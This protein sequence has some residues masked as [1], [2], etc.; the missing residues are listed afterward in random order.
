MRGAA[1]AGSNMENFELAT[2]AVHVDEG[3]LSGPVV[4]SPRQLWSVGGYLDMVIQGVFG[5]GEDGKVTP[6]LPVALV[7]MLFGDG[8]RISL[9]LAD[10][11]IVL[12]RPSTLDGNL[13][14]TGSERRDGKR[15]EIALKAVKIDAPPLRRDAPLYAPATPDAPKVTADGKRWRIQADGELVLYVNGERHGTVRDAQIERTAAQQCFSLTRVDEHG[16]ESLH[17]AAVCRGEEARIGGAWPRAWT[18]PSSGRFELSLEYANDHGPINTGITAAVQVATVSCE[19]VPAQSLVLVLPHSAGRQRSTRGSFAAR[20]GQ[21]CKV[22][23]APGFNMS[24]L[25]HFAHYTGGQ[26]GDG[27]PLNRAEVGDMLIVPLAPGST[28]P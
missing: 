11:E 21:P 13:L 18:A 10:Q 23:L 12:V 20:Q 6:K 8:Q 22:E 15:I 9:S 2:Q 17:S 25:A 28:A 19:G 1:L 27:G 3:P 16:I 26:G 5:L 4:D 24:Y 7:P 14:V